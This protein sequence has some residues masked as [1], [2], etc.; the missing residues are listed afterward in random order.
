MR[1][2]VAISPGFPFLGFSSSL[3]F[4]FLGFSFPR[5]AVRAAAIAVIGLMATAAAPPAGAETRIFFVEN[6]PDDYGIDECLASGASCGRSMAS[7]F[8]RAHEYDEAV[9]FRRA[10]PQEMVRET[11]GTACTAG[12]CSNLIVI[13]CQ[14]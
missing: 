14:R 1:N 5:S 11:R 2:L 12:D 10:E 3:G 6:Q 13:E 4:P 9:S 7:T 8:C